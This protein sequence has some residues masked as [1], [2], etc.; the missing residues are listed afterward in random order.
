MRSQIQRDLLTLVQQ[1]PGIRHRRR[2]G[3]E[4][5]TA[6]DG[7]SGP[8]EL[9]EAGITDTEVVGDFVDER[10]AD[11]TCEVVLVDRALAQRTTEHDDAVGHPARREEAARGL[12]HTL[13]E[14]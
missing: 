3:G 5:A 9:A 6:A 7:R 12:G 14:T 13:V 10:D 8:A 4:A 1:V 2:L 11:L